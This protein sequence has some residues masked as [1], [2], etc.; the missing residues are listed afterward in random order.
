VQI[1]RAVQK[2]ARSKLCAA[3]HGFVGFDLI[4]NP[5]RSDRKDPVKAGSSATEPVKPSTGFR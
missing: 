3:L 5:G 4:D 1:K 2:E